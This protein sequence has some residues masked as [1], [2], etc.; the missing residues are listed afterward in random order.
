MALWAFPRRED[1]RRGAFMGTTTKPKLKLIGKNGNAFSILARAKKALIEAGRE[2]E[3]E[4]YME[5][6]TSGD[7]DHLLRVTMEWFEVE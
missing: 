1:R 6:A 7:Y 4:E 2:E 5:E 3:I